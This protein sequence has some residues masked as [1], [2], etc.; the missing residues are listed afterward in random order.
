MHLFD[1]A[2]ISERRGMKNIQSSL[3]AISELKLV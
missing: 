3:K 2:V 1:T